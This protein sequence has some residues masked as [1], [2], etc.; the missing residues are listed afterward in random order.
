MNQCTE[1]SNRA[2]WNSDEVMSLRGIRKSVIWLPHHDLS[3]LIDRFYRTYI[4]GGLAD[5]QIASRYLRD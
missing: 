4:D 5:L 2:S 1:L 3:L